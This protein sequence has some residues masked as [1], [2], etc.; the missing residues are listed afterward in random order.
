MSWRVPRDWEGETAVLLAGGPSLRGF[1]A[2]CLG[3]GVRVI[4]INDSWRLCPWAD[5]FYFCDE[6]WWKDQ[7]RRNIV[8]TDGRLHFWDLRRGPWIK[9]GEPTI[10]DPHVRILPF[11]GQ[12]G[13]EK[14]P[15]M[16]RHGSN[17][18]YAAINL[19]YHFGAKKII[20]LGYDM[21]VVGARSNWHEGDRPPAAQYQQT[22]ARSMLPLFDTLVAPLKEAGV[23]VVNATPGTALTCWRLGALEEELSKHT[24][25]A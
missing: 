7:L 10:S 23:E 22:L 18:G 19:A 3:T 17:S 25:G 13:L 11:S 15:G 21:H 5:A 2:Q 1:N 9:G 8:A 14:N 4:T 6:P 20:L 24:K 16:L 12:V